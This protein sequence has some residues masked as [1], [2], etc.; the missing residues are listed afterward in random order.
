M[1]NEPEFSVNSSKLGL[2]R[3]WEKIE[4]LSDT[5]AP[6]LLGL[7]LTYAFVRGVAAGTGKAYWYDEMLT[8][9]VI[10]QGSMSKIMSA[11]RALVDGQPPLFY[12][13]ET[14]STRLV[15]NRDIALRLPAAFGVVCAMFCVYIFLQRQ[16]GRLIALLSAAFLMTTV[17]FTAYAAEARP[18]GLLVACIAFALVCYQRSASPKWVV[19]L[20]ASLMLAESLH[21]MAVLSMLPFVLAELFES[22]QLKRI[23]WGIWAAFASGAV[24]LLLFWH[25][26]AM[27]KA[28]YGAHAVTLGFSIA[29][30]VHSYGDL[31]VA[32]GPIGFGIAMTAAIG[33]AITWRSPTR[34][35]AE[36]ARAAGGNERVLAAGLLALPLIAYVLV[37]AT[38]G[39]MAV[40]Y[41]LPCVLG[42]SLSFGIALARM[43]KEATLVFAAYL[44]STAGLTE[45]H[46]WRFIGAERRDLAAKPAAT[47]K[48][49][50]SVGYPQLPIVIPNGDVLWLAHYAFPQPPKRLVYLTQDEDGPGDTRDKGLAIA[51]RYVPITV[52]RAADFIASNPKFIIYVEGGN[53][54]DTW[55]TQRLLRDRWSVELLATDGF[56]AIYLLQSPKNDAE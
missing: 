3:I 56:R 28:Y 33:I 39:K 31:L 12:V 30:A 17:A 55:I 35:G 1:V 5:F 7:L 13:I 50:D 8:H 21:Y 36:P 20:A 52:L 48:L 53:S 24:P 51:Q 43:P 29:F 54:Q 19:L 6:A 23:R 40:R 47:L 38:H 25:L 42:I 11:L 46:F 22:V 4:K 9:L 41:F 14:V 26:L 15:A 34:I 18:Y 44:F 49:V 10:A 45:L 32:D 2:M 37:L 27:I 16:A